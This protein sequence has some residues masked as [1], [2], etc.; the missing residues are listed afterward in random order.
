HSVSLLPAPLQP[1]AEKLQAARERLSTT[2]LV[3]LGVTFVGVVGL[4]IGSTWY[5]NAPEYRV[6]YSDLSAESASQVV[7]KLT[8]DNVEYRLADS[9]RTV[10]VPADRLDTLRLSF[11]GEGVPVSG[12]M[13]FE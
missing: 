5:L 2:Q 10:L 13:G 4:L 11:A 8:A 1:Y 3:T 12:R 7:D 6:L 9:G